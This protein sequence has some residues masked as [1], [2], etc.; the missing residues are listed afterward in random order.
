MGRAGNQTLWDMQK[1]RH[2]FTQEV[3][4]EILNVSL[5]D[6]VAEDMIVWRDDQNGEYRVKLGT[7]H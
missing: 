3:V 6:D 5:L 1:V 4:N 2:L 7:G